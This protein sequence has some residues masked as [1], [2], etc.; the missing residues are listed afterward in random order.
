MRGVRSS[1]LHKKPRQ[2]SSTF[3]IYWVM[4]DD[5]S[6]GWAS[7]SCSQVFSCKQFVDFVLDRWEMFVP[8]PLTKNPRQLSSTFEFYWVLTDHVSFG[9]GDTG[10]NQV[11][12][13]KQFG[14]FFL[15]RWEVFVLHPCT[16]TPDSCQALFEFYWWMTDA[17]LFEWGHTGY[18]QV[19]SCKQ[20]VDFD[21]QCLPSC[22]IN[23]Q[24]L[25]VNATVLSLPIQVLVHAGWS[26]Q[27]QGR[28][29][30]GCRPPSV[31]RCPEAGGVIK[32]L[33]ISQRWV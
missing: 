10:C 21:E 30:A 25:R 33:L 31:G 23:P 15:D 22:K 8:H 1:S 18:T 24:V 3:C 26:C 13:C 20:F 14:D 2:L 29:L 32:Q 17:V 9:W 19:I 28:G 4:T 27:C 5:V 7:T 11:F 12:S 16:K 6:F